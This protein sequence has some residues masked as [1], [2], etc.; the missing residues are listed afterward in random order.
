MHHNYKQYRLYKANLILFR[1]KSTLQIDIL[2]NNAG[3]SQRCW[4]KDTPLSVHKD[5]FDINLFAMMSLTTEVLPSMIE[6]RKG[7]IVVTNSIQGKMGECIEPIPRHLYLN[8]VK[9]ATMLS[10]YFI[11]LPLLRSLHVL[12]ILLILHHQITGPLLTSLDE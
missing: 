12:A 4:I 1:I 10:K 11:L 9:F 8:I 7:H 2:V 5:L 6:R 3:R